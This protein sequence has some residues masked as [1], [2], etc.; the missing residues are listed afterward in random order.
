MTRERMYKTDRICQ[1]VA[2]NTE[3]NGSPCF[4]PA[5]AEGRSKREMFADVKCRAVTE[6]AESPH[7]KIASLGFSAFDL[8]QPELLF[9]VY[10]NQILLR[11]A[12]NYSSHWSKTQ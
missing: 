10:I 6:P 8:K 1:P 12:S 4:S 11:N 9:S 5:G 2:I 7:S 3:A